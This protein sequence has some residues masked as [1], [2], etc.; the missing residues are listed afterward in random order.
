MTVNHVVTLRLVFAADVLHDP[1]VPTLHDDVGRVVVPAEAG[2]EVG[3]VGVA[4]ELARVV[5][6]AREQDGRPVRALRDQD[7]RVQLHAVAHRDHDFAPVVVEAFGRGPERGR[8]LARIARVLRGRGRGRLGGGHRRA[9][10]GRE[11]GQH[12]PGSNVSDELHAVAL[13]R[14]SWDAAATLVQARGFGNGLAG[15]VARSYCERLRS[16]ARAAS[17][18]LSRAVRAILTGWTRGGGGV[19][20]VAAE[21]PVAPPVSTLSIELGDR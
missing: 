12:D 21:T 10:H 13:A 1:D 15:W 11:R 7:H 16:R 9:T 5:G 14:A 2:A 19:K 17:A 4:R 3:A 6:R 18:A 20:R 8:R